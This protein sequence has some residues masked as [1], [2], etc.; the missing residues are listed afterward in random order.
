M[1]K[2]YQHTFPQPFH[3]SV[4]AVLFNEKKEVCVHHFHTEKIP[5]TLQFLAGGLD[6]FYL[7]MRESVEGDESLQ[8]AVHRGLLEEFGAVGSI[9]RYLGALTCDVR[10]NERIFEKTT[11]YHAVELQELRERALVDEESETDMEWHSPRDV[12]SLFRS[13]GSRT[14]RKELDESLIIERFIATYGV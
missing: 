13:Q 1:E 10:S 12:L 11:L 9:D 3:L 4:G 5:E 8:Q 2:F 6:E 14:E 7:L